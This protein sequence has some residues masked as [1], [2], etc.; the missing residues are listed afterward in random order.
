V[1]PDHDRSFIRCRFRSSPDVEVEAVLADG[2]RFGAIELALGIRSLHTGSGQL[3]GFANAGPIRGR[4]GCAPSQIADGRRGEG[5]SF[6]DA[7]VGI[8]AGDAGEFSL[9]DADG[10]VDGGREWKNR[11]ED[12]CEGQTGHSEYD[13]GES[14]Q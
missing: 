6:K 5:D 9:F 3:V 11:G 12:S 7:D 4:F 13:T 2:L 8:R 1:N 14:S 10:V